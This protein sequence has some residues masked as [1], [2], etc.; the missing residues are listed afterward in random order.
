MGKIL[1]LIVGI[2][3][4][5]VGLFLFIIWRYEFFILIRGILPL[6]LILAGLISLTAGY[7]EIRDYNK[8]KAEKK[9]NSK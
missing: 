5:G 2:V 3:M 1:S 7:M 8:A 9:N 4:A 6:F